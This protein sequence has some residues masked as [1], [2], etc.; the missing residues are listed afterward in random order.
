MPLIPKVLY[1]KYEINANQ[2]LRYYNYIHIFLNNWP[3]DRQNQTHPAASP[4][5]QTY[6]NN[7]LQLT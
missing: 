6:K 4:Q 2:S 5:F 7:K 1:E 3:V